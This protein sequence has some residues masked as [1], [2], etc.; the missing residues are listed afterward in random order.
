MA[1]PKLE[2]LVLILGKDIKFFLL[3]LLMHILII[4]HVLKNT[5]KKTPQ[6]PIFLSEKF[7][8]MKIIEIN[9]AQKEQPLDPKKAIDSK[10][11]KRKLEG[12]KWKVEAK[13]KR[14][15]TI[16]KKR[17]SINAQNSDIISK[18]TTPLPAAITLTANYPL[19]SRRLREE[20]TVVLTIRCNTSCSIEIVQ[21][22]GY[23]RLDNAAKKSLGIY[24][25]NN[26]EP[27]TEQIVKFNF[28]L[29]SS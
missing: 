15:P 17:P 2:R 9:T 5:P 28:N 8:G 19:V 10:I 26:K 1:K 7:I 23:I 24:L 20:G 11:K 29:R 27:L 6:V 16:A 21:S 14:K 22:S 13:Q 4:Y 25:K 12:G 18:K 3:S